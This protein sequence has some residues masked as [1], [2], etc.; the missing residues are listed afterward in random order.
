MGKVSRRVKKKS[1]G[2]PP[3]SPTG[4]S[5]DGAQKNGAPE[6]RTLSTPLQSLVAEQKL[7]THINDAELRKN[8]ADRL[9][10]RAQRLLATDMPAFDDA[11]DETN[12]RQSLSEI[13]DAGEPLPVKGGGVDQRGDA[14]AWSGT[15][16]A[17]LLGQAELFFRWP[18]KYALDGE[19]ILRD[20]V[21]E[22]YVGGAA[23]L[24]DRKRVFALRFELAYE[25][26]AVDASETTF[27]E[28]GELSLFCKKCA[29]FRLNHLPVC[30]E[31]V[32]VADLH[33]NAPIPAHIGGLWNM[34]K[35]I[36][37]HLDGELT[38]TKLAQLPMPSRSWRF[39]KLPF[40]VAR[41]TGIDDNEDE[42]YTI[43]EP[44]EFI[45]EMRKYDT[46]TPDELDAYERLAKKD[47]CYMRLE[48]VLGPTVLLEDEHDCGHCHGRAHDNVARVAMQHE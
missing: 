23:H 47:D 33:E 25:L 4:A 30:F 9:R 24:Y 26:H 12:F 17:T 44:V 48:S 29:K 3:P 13:I 10:R 39:L 6:L 8:A 28:H 40:A 27:D 2:T 15:A 19:G 38:F 37:R 46:P 31:L 43:I 7:G 1:H 11:M 21:D 22:M 32:L 35:P 41:V 34:L 45:A 42:T 36:K 14:I 18:S 16:G 20:L 5:C